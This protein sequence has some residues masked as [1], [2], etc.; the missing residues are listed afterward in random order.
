MNLLRRV[1]RRFRH[2]GLPAIWASLAGR[3]ADWQ[4]VRAPRLWA[5]AGRLS[6]AIAQKWPLQQPAVL[7]LSL[8]RSGSSWVG[9]TLGSAPNAVYLREPLTQSFVG[10]GGRGGVVFPFP[11]DNPPAVY[12]QAAR[13]AFAGLPRFEHLPSVVMDP[14]QWSLRS[15]QQR[16]LV[17][18]EVNP[19]LCGW[20]GAEYRPH[21]I[22]LLRHPAAIAMSYR[23][24]GWWSARP[25]QWE[26]MGRKF[27]AALLAAQH[28]LPGLAHTRVVQYEALC[29]EPQAQFDS[30]LEFAELD[31]TDELHSLV[32]QRTN[33]SDD[34]NPASLVKIS[35]QHIDSWR[36]E[37]SAEEL[38]RLRAGYCHYPLPWYQAPDDW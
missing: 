8:P 3:A 26:A 23:R 9:N 32:R 10:A 1:N 21:V 20:L 34:P 24:L 12:G 19:H 11:P 36:R 2:G 6:E 22:L 17:I 7:V 13:L 25:E 29:V 16:R 15:R 14:R 30:L 35:A 31:A 27:G 5:G 18:K 33:T 37:I 38:A 28:S 4:R